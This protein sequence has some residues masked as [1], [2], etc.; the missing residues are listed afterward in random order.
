MSPYAWL[1]IV[2]VIKSTFDCNAVTCQHGCPAKSSIVCAKFLFRHFGPCFCLLSPG[3]IA[4]DRRP[5]GTSL[6]AVLIMWQKAKGGQSSWPSLNT[7]R[8]GR[9]HGYSES[10]CVHVCVFINPDEV[11][12]VFNLL[13]LENMSRSS[14]LE[15]TLRPGSQWAE[16]QLRPTLSAVH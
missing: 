8:T 3:K 13:L 7:V 12:V 5:K 6:K 1:V 2:S 14:S 11:R 15:Q 9:P 4:V 10:V 16:L